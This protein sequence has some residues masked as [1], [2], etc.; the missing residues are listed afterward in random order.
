MIINKKELGN[1]EFELGYTLNELYAMEVQDSYMV[2][3]TLN[4]IKR[5][6]N[7]DW[8]FLRF[9]SINTHIHNKVQS[10]EDNRMLWESF[11]T[12]CNYGLKYA[13][14]RV[15]SLKNNWDDDLSSRITSTNSYI[16]ENVKTTNSQLS[17][18]KGITRTLD[19]IADYIVF[20]KF[21]NA[22][23]EQS[24][25]D[26][27]NEIQSIEKIKKKKRKENDQKRV[28]QAKEES[29]NTPSSYTR[30]LKQPPK[31]YKFTSAERI[32]E[33]DGGVS[34]VENTKVNYSRVDKQMEK[35]KF[36]GSM[37]EFWD[38]YSPSKP[39]SIP[40]YH[41]H[42]ENYSDFAYSV[43]KQ[44]IDEI[45]YLED[46]PFSIDRP[47]QISNIKTEMRIALDVLRK[48]IHLQPTNTIDETIP[49]DAWNRLSLRNT[50]T[51]AALLY[52]YYEASKQYNN[53]PSTNFW[54]LLR[55][56]EELISNTNWNIEEK[57]I[58]EFI[59]ET[60]VTDQKSIQLNLLEELGLEVPQRNISNIINKYIPN[61]LL[62]TYE[63]RLED[64]IWIQRRKG[65]YKTCKKCNEVKLAVDNRY[66]H[67]KQSGVLGLK[68]IC[69]RCIKK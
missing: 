22:K 29:H 65:T 44:Y 48:E 27:K 16:N 50:D 42:P 24:H 31:H 62:N 34:P 5:V 57:V 53:K 7:E 19:K 37:K 28:I 59:L 4:K 54:A 32:I 2:K 12:S 63:D 39:N 1:Y 9:D 14:D 68:A 69:K 11:K 3:N 45:T 52:G 17:G 55:T 36:D 49:R 15:D 67:T 6:S 64:W 40:W 60:G 41:N 51:Y 35:G 56:F 30:K 25:L 66:Y 21:D 10:N 43:M 8:V 26:V 38:R 20:A 13:Q 61:K 46:L 18:E 33:E 47:K 58:L 23:Q